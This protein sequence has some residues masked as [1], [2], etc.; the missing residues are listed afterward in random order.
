[1]YSLES[2]KTWSRDEYHPY[3]FWWLNNT[4]EAHSNWSDH[5]LITENF[6]CT[7]ILILLNNFVTICFQT[8]Y[9]VLTQ[10]SHQENTQIKNS[11]QILNSVLKF[12][13]SFVFGP[14]RTS[15]TRKWSV[16]LWAWVFH[17]IYVITLTLILYPNYSRWDVGQPNKISLFCVIFQQYKWVKRGGCQHGWNHVTCKPKARGTSTQ[18]PEEQIG[19]WRKKSVSLKQEVVWSS[20]SR[21]EPGDRWSCQCIFQRVYTPKRSHCTFPLL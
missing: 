5:F 18:K 11:E 1:M 15:F 13:E 3:T 10:Q 12:L 6:F 2:F 14:W 16:S 17:G 19:S 21:S 8:W 4:A 9:N 20:W 7:F